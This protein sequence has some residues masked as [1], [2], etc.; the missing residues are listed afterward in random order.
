[1]GRLESPIKR[2]YKPRNTRGI[3]LKEERPTKHTKYT[4][5]KIGE[6]ARTTVAVRQSSNEG[7]GEFLFRVFRVFRG[8]NRSF[9]VYRWVS[10]ESSQNKK[11]ASY[12]GTKPDQSEC[13]T[14]FSDEPQQVVKACLSISKPRSPHLNSS[15][16]A[17]SASD[18]ISGFPS[19]VK[20]ATCTR[21]GVTSGHF[22]ATV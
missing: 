19:P 16:N 14:A 18:R 9:Q 7:P 10:G 13:S 12:C 6:G 3:S 4:K 5:G 15:T 22:S 11:T 17:S 20:S 2:Q 21:N 8:L 1:M